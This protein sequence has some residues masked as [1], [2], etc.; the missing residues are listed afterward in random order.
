AR[1][2]Y[3]AILDRIEAQGYDVFSRRAETSRLGK[4]VVAARCAARDPGEIL[5]RGRPPGRR[6]IRPPIMM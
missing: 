4:L 1:E 5:A 2:L 3:A 6:C